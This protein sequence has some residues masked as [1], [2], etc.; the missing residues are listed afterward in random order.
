MMLILTE[1]IIFG[2]DLHVQNVNLGAFYSLNV[3]PV[4]VWMNTGLISW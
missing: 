4:P 2:K 1:A 3:K